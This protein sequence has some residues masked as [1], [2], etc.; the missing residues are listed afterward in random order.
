MKV[1]QGAKIPRQ[2][3]CET[4]DLRAKSTARCLLGSWGLVRSIHEQREHSHDIHIYIYI[5]MYAHSPL[6]PRDPASMGLG[7]GGNTPNAIE[8]GSAL[9]CL[10]VSKHRALGPS[11]HTLD[12]PPH[13]MFETRFH[14]WRF[15]FVVNGF[16]LV[17][18]CVS[19]HR[20]LGPSS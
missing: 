9:Y 20:A 12:T 18:V 8:T 15:R 4:D 19:R 1:L 3:R 6:T 11:S 17:E 2:A 10:C 7:S 13:R 16:S 14:I 5:Y